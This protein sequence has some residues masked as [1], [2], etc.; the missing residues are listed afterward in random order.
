MQL[1]AL[2]VAGRIPVTTLSLSREL[3]LVLHCV[4]SPKGKLRKAEKKLDLGI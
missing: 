2:S 4:P 1:E 3:P